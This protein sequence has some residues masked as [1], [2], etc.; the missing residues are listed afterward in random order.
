MAEELNNPPRSFYF[1]SGFA[2]LWN[3]LGVGAYVSQMTMSPEVLNALPEAER[4]LYENV[5][6]WATSAFA[7]AVNAGAMGCLLLLMRKA[8]ATPVLI[9][10]L[11]GVVVQLIHSLFMSNS[12]EVYGPGGAIMPITVMLIGAYLVWY[13]ID[14]KNNNSPNAE[15]L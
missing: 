8:F 9:A 12:I 6:V 15:S 1:I 7:I 10:S 13:S 11:A 2:L 14:A 4:M 3:L 5:P